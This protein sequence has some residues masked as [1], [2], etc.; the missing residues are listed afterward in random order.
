MEKR[1]ICIIILP[2]PHSFLMHADHIWKEQGSGRAKKNLHLCTPTLPLVPSSSGPFTHRTR[3]A[4]LFFDVPLNKSA[5]HAGNS[6]RDQHFLFYQEDCVGRSCFVSSW[7]TAPSRALLIQG[8]LKSNLNNLH[9]VGQPLMT[10][11]KA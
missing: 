5:M 11:A 1:L 7:R 2:T 6:Q 8:S 3:K 9:S 4:C 10:S